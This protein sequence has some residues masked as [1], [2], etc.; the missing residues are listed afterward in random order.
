M[1]TTN[2]MLEERQ[3]FAIHLNIKIGPLVESCGEIVLFF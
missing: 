3:K 2:Q 1:D